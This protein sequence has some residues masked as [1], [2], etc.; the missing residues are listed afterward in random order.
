[1]KNRGQFEK[2]IKGFAGITIDFC[3]LFQDITYLSYAK[4]RDLERDK[5]DIINGVNTIQKHI[6]DLCKLAWENSLL[7]DPRNFTVAAGKIKDTLMQIN[8][9]NDI[10]KYVRFQQ[11]EVH[12]NDLTDELAY[13]LYSEFLYLYSDVCSS[14]TNEVIYPFKTNPFLATYSDINTNPQPAIQ[15]SFTIF[16]D[17]LR[18]KIGADASLYGEDLMNKAFGR[19]GVLIYSN[20]PAEQNGVRN[21]FSGFYATFRNPHMHRI[22]QIEENQALAIISTIYLL[23]D[24]VNNSQ[25]RS[26]GE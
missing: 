20:I 23:L 6:L 3:Y 15:Q 11:G 2:L 13:K 1:M 25:M 16:E 4:D 26:K 10:E 18:Y 17:Y 19:D 9:L 12:V 5:A 14:I 22:I 21:L 7:L 24:I 8:E